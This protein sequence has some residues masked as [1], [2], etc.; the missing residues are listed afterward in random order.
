[1]IKW[2]FFLTGIMAGKTI[3]LGKFQFVSGGLEITATPE[4]MALYARTLER[5]WSAYP[6]GDPR[7][8]PEQE[9]SDGQR[10]LSPNP[11]GDNEQTLRS[12]SESDGQ[13][14]PAGQ[15]TANDGSGNASAEAG[16]GGLQTGGDGQPAELTEK[17]LE[18]LPFVNEKLKR[19]IEK[20]DPAEDSH[21]IADG[22]PAI[23]AVA[24]LYGATDVTRADVEAVAPGFT[25][26]AKE[27]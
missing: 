26:P 21:W 24:M 2:M 17:P 12:G 6:K 8:T 13:G 22:R 14:A 15:P 7:L 11:I 1:M 9:N 18:P 3:K 27:A 16:Q 19:A 10:D 4:Q 20:L 25:R 23:A 5:N